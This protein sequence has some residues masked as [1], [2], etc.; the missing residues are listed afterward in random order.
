MALQGAVSE[1]AS[2]PAASIELAL[3]VAFIG[4]VF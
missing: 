3:R 4:W 1:L 2:R